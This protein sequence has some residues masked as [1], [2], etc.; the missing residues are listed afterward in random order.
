MKSP[1]QN[2]DYNEDVSVADVHASVK[3]EQDDP[4]T[5]LEPATIRVFAICA[6]FLMIGGAYLGANGGFNTSSVIPGYT[7]EPPGGVVP[8][9]GPGNPR[10]EW[11]KAG[12]DKY[13]ACAGCHQPT[14]VGAPGM[15]PP[16]AGSEWVTGGTDRLA[17]LIIHGLAGPITV[18]GQTYPGNVPMPPHGDIFSSEEIAQIMTYIRNSWGNKASFVSTEMVDAARK[19]HAEQSGPFKNATLPAPDADLPGVLP[20]WAG[21]P[22]AAGGAAE[23]EAETAP[24]PA[25]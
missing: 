12:K 14:G 22:P 19:N 24:E 10:E 16:L 20:E 7:P 21:G 9:K 6:V 2:P 23:P 25:S 13:G 3:R 15:Y 8:P 11:L 17:A 5:G 4:Q 1:Q 18:K